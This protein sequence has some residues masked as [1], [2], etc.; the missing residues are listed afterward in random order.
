MAQSDMALTRAATDGRFSL[1]S[2]DYALS[3]RVS[4][5][6]VH[7]LTDLGFLMLAGEWR[8]GCEQQLCLTAEG[9]R[10]GRSL[11]GPLPA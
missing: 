8:F 2:I 5:E 3:F 1:T 4:P 11:S 7:R 9:W 6:A 10:R